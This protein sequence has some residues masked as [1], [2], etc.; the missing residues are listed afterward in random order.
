MDLQDYLIK[1]R[2]SRTG[3]GD[4]VAAKNRLRPLPMAGHA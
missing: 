4:V 2:Q 3:D 1:T